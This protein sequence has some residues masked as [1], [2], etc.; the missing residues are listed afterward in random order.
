F[1]AGSTVIADK[2]LPFCFGRCDFGCLVLSFGVAD[3][4]FVFM[5]VIF[6]SAGTDSVDV[7]LIFGVA[8]TW[9]MC[10]S[11]PFDGGSFVGAADPLFEIE[12][13][14]CSARFF[15]FSNASNNSRSFG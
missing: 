14:Y 11:V 9:F 8:I 4:R 1:R 7:L 15:S 3:S 2:L 10:V 13:V 5:F 12:V 6:D